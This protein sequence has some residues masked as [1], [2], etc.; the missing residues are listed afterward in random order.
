M[1]YMN[2][3]RRAEKEKSITETLKEQKK[4]YEKERQEKIR[5]LEMQIQELKKG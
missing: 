2:K 5:S 1:V 4:Q 3:S